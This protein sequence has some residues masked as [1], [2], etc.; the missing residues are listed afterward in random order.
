MT[1]NQQ[2]C[3]QSNF[4]HLVLELSKP[5]QDYLFD[6][7]LENGL[8]TDAQYKDLHSS[9][10]SS[11]NRACQLH[12]LV[13]SSSKPHSF[14]LFCDALRNANLTDAL[15]P[16]QPADLVT[17]RANAFYGTPWKFYTCMYV[18][19]YLTSNPGNVT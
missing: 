19:T 5:G 4:R 9:T 16:L 11:M 17:V 6:C 18:Y 14:D 13:K 10:D 8:L 1:P 3:I 2:R 15:K 7:C 12:M